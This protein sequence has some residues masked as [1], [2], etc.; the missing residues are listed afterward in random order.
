ML[1]FVLRKEIIATSSAP[2]ADQ[3]LIES[4]RI[5]HFIASLSVSKDVNLIAADG[6]AR[7]HGGQIF[8]KSTRVSIDK[9]ADDY[10]SQSIL[11]HL[12]I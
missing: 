9:S 11:I 4:D 3:N 8:S 7:M 1:H 12:I 5:N 6:K 10:L 2:L